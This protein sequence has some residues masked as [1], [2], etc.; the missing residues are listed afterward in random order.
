M[1][2]DR[3]RR[4]LWV[5]L[6]LNVIVAV[7]K[8]VFGLMAGSMSMV[9]DALHSSF[10]SA[11]NIIGLAATGI[12]A[13]PPDRDHPYG[14]AKFETFGTLLVGGM[15]LLTAYWVI[16]EGVVRLTTGAVP[17]ITALTV[18]VMV[19]TTV[20]N[21]FVALYERRVGEELRSSFL[22]ADSEHTKSDVFVSLSVLLGFA[23]VY[24]GYPLADPLIALAIGALIGRMGLSIIR[25]AGMVLTDAATVQCEENVREIVARIRGVLGSHEFRCRG[26][27]GE[28]MADIHIT[29]DP[30]MTVE[31]A[32]GIAEEVEAAITEGV[33]GM[34][35]V[36][37]HIEPGERDGREKI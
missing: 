26:A 36:V 25:E 21:I 18:G 20:I 33:P 24:L 28:M 22:I 2:Y 23:V 7:A 32:H 3:V 14:H 11:S 5:I 9:A 8:A 31:E 16:S 15:L 17:H 19:A 27:P 35:E 6:I 30:G 1:E 13:R 37:V 29:V 4:T 10:D 34:K 12:A